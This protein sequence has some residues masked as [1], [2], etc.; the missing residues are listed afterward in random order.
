MVS[1]SEA[2]DLIGKDKI[3][4]TNDDIELSYGMSDARDLE[5]LDRNDT[6]I[7]DYRRSSI[8]LSKITN[9]IRTKTTIILVRVDIDGPPHTNPDGR[10]IGGTHMHLYREG[11]EDKF[12][13]EINPNIFTD[14]SDMVLTMKQF[15]DY[16][17]IKDL[18]KIVQQL[19]V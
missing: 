1:D 8:K 11:Y 15:C 18:P 3:F 13:E 6:F 4:I 10:R 2:I 12:A 16:C 17:N 5:S 7:L 19:Q 14:T 9:Q